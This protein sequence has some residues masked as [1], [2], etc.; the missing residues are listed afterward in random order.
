MNT[1]GLLNYLKNR[2]GEVLDEDFSKKSEILSNEKGTAKI[3]DFVSA[4]SI[5][6]VEEEH[7]IYALKKKRKVGFLQVCSRLIKCSS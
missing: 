2:K 7:R 3:Y 1:F 6:V 5:F 4:S